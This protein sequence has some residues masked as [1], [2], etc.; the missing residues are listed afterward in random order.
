LEP[1]PARPAERWFLAIRPGNTPENHAV[2]K[3]TEGWIRE[4]IALH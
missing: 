1:D 2:A 4:W 3:I